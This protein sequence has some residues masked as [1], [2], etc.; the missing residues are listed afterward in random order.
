[1]FWTMCWLEP[2]MNLNPGGNLEIYSKFHD[3]NNMNYFACAHISLLKL[4]KHHR[5]HTNYTDCALKVKLLESS[6]TTKVSL[7]LTKTLQL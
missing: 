3:E 6:T 1:M 5:H 4:Y 2:G 7:T